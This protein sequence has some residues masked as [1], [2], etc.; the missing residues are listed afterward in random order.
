MI[1]LKDLFVHVCVVITFLFIG[2][3]L[4]RKGPIFFESTRQKVLLGVFGGVLGSFLMGFTIPLSPTIIMDFRHVAVLLSALYGGGVA[5]F[6]S[7]VIICF[8]RAVF[9]GVST[10]LF[11]SVFLMIIIGAF[12][13]YI[14]RLR[15]SEL[16]KWLYMYVFSLILLTLG[17]L[18]LL[19]MSD[20]FI[21]SMFKYWVISIVGGAL[22]FYCAN[23]IIQSNRMFNEMKKESTT[24]YL[25]GLSNVRYFSYKLYDSIHKAK[26]YREKLSFLMLDIDYFKKVNDTFG[27]AA[28]DEVLRK[29][30]ALITSCVRSFDIVSRIG[31]EEFSVLLLSCDHAQALEIAEKIRTTVES[32]TIRLVS[33]KQITITISVGAATYLETT[34]SPEQL[35]TQADQALYQAKHTG[36]NKVCSPFVS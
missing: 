11:V 35:V 2:G 28:G 29:L 3:I 7:V 34:E 19:G 18:Y 31:G 36:R 27:H 21:D 13:A 15:I 20:V 14:S 1:M 10:S 16:K 30:S 33:G 6:V 17:F 23:F 4:Y 5:A 24:D 26:E 8:S 25:T 9:F 22:I 12:A 32:S